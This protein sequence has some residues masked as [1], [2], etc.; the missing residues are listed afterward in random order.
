MFRYS[1]NNIRLLVDYLQISDMCLRFGCF[2]LQNR[3]FSFCD[4]YV[5]MLSFVS[6][7]LVFVCSVDE[8]FEN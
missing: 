5:Q 4:V 7:I 1:M 6:E 2:A 8:V 3:K